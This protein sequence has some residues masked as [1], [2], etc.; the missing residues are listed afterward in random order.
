M[1]LLRL[2]DLPATCFDGAIPAVIATCAQ[3]GTPNA[4]WLSQVFLVD[5]RHIAVSCQFFRKTQQNL[6]RDPR[7]QLLMSSPSEPDQW[8]LDLRLARSETSGPLFDDM[9]RRIQAIASLTGK[10][11]VFDLRSAEVFE[12]MMI[13]A[14]EVHA[15]RAE[16]SAKPARDPLLVLSR[17]SEGI[18]ACRGLD[19]LVQSG[20]GLLTLHLE[21]DSVSLYLAEETEQQ[22]YALASRGYPASGVGA[23]IDYGVGL[24][25]TCARQRMPIRIA[26]MARDLRYGRVVREQ[27]E[28][29]S[30]TL[31]REVP[32]PGLANAAS[33]LSV[34]LILDGELFGVLSTES[35]RMLA[36]DERDVL[37]LSTA[38]QVLAQAIARHREDEPEREHRDAPH[39]SISAK[40]GTLKVRYYEADDSVFLDDTYLIK[41]LPGRILWLLLSVR[42]REGRDTFTN[43]EL[44]LHPWL[45]L[46]SYHDNLEARLL[47]LQRR[48]QDK[49]SPLR[50][51]RAQRGR[52]RVDCSA[53]LELELVPA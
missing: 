39:A 53:T 35:T 18:S 45:K 32:L 42:E 50:L 34:P 47:M 49:S 36:Y 9:Q 2:S 23:R 30:G 52:M 19:A 41:G 33:S 46:P 4:T 1:N 20:L 21:L 22:L 44:R 24:V 29:A 25:G 8:R 16:V 6:L 51:E 38:G 28:R 14:V 13:T 3:D 27:V 10:Q 31:E 12:V 48:L 15:Q 43:R 37:L 7:A 11:G 17:I 26:D 40:T 5:E